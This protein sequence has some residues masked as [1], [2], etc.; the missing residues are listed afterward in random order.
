MKQLNFILLII[1]HN[2]IIVFAKHT[3]VNIKDT[4]GTYQLNFKATYVTYVN[5]DIELMITLPE[6]YKFVASVPG[7]KDYI[8]AT[9]L[10][11]TIY[12]TKA[13][14]DNS[15]RTN[16]ALHVITPEGIEEKL[17]FRIFAKR[18]APK[19]EAIHFESP[20][21]SELNRTVEKI[22][23]RYQ[24]QL[25]QALSNQEN[26][27][28]N[29]IHFETIRKGMP[30][31]VHKRR[32]RHLVTYKGAT[33]QF[34][35]MYN[36]RSETYIYI[37]TRIK[38]LDNCEIIEVEKAGAAKAMSDATFVYSYADEYGD[39]IHIYKIPGIRVKYKKNRVKKQQFRIQ[40]R[41]WSKQFIQKFKIS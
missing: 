7:S 21:A 3:E 6:G 24:S 22:K 33:A 18:N 26:V 28:E 34:Y 4:R 19:V 20:N 10:Q 36:S 2:V 11:N 41:I 5:M 35:G 40:Y 16:L 27:L 37:K 1:M 32:G 17:M 8:S 25:N 9:S 31:F 14:E 39:W 38:N 30:W 13:S 23:A 15:F 12:V 29:T